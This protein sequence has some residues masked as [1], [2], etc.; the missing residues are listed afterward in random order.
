[1]RIDLAK[2]GLPN[3]RLACYNKR[4]RCL[5]YPGQ[6]TALGK[7]LRE[8]RKVPA[9]PV[10]GWQRSDG[11]HRDYCT[12]GDFMHSKKR[13]YLG[14]CLLLALL[15]AITWPEATR[16][17]SAEPDGEIARF[18]ERRLRDP[19]APP[20][21]PSAGVADAPALD[22]LRLWQITTVDVPPDGCDDVSMALDSSGRP[23]IAYHE[24]IYNDGDLKYAHDD[25]TGWQIQ[26]VDT[27]GNVGGSASLALD[28][29]GRP[30]IAYRDYSH[31]SIKYAYYDG[32]SWHIERAVGGCQAGEVVL[33]LD[34]G[35]QPHISYYTAYP[36]F[37]LRYAHFDGTSWQDELVDTTGYVGGPS[38]AVDAAG[39]PHIFYQ[40]W[41]SSRLRYA[42]FD[43][44]IWQLETLAPGSSRSGT[45]LALDGQ[46]RPHVAYLTSSSAGYGW[47]DGSA[48][49]FEVVPG[50]AGANRPALT[51]DAA[52]RPHISYIDSSYRGV[53]SYRNVEYAWH[54]GSTWSV[55]PVDAATTSSGY[56]YNTTSVAVDAAGMP[57]I[58]YLGVAPAESESIRYAI[59]QTN[60]A[61][62]SRLTFASYRDMN[63]EI[64]AAQ[65][66][67]SNPARLT[68]HGATDS[69]PAY[70]RGCSQ[71]AFDSLRPGNYDLYKMNADGSGITQLT[72]APN[73]DYLA[74]WS[75]DGSKIAYFG[76]PVDAYN[77]EVFVMNADGSGQTRLTWDEAWDGHPTWSPDGS[78]LAFVSG[79]SGAYELWTMN[80]DGSNQQQL[81][82]GLNYPAY[83]DWSPDGSRIVL[84][85]DYNN[86]G[87]LDLAIINADGT[88]LVHPLGASPGNYDRLAPTWSPHGQA[89][90]FARI[91]YIYYQG[92][93]YW[94]DAYIYGLDVS[95][96]SSY[97]L[98]DAGYDWWP[99][100]QPTE[101]VP[102]Q[103]QVGGL[104]Q[105]SAS[106]FLVTWGGWDPGGAGLRSYDVQYREGVD[107]V[108]TDWLL[109]TTQTG[110]TF[111]G[112]DGQTYYFRCRARDYAYNVEP[113]PDG[114]GDA[115][116]T[117]D[118]SP[119]ESTADSP[120]YASTPVFAVTWSGSD[121]NSGI[122][123]YD[124]QYRDG[125]LPWTNWL[126]ATT[127]T[128]AYFAGQINHTYYFQ[129]R[130]RDNVGNLE[131]YPAYYGDTHTHT[132]PYALTGA[133]RGNRA[134]PIALAEV[135]ASPAL[136]TTAF[137]GVDGAFVLYGHATGTYTLS[138]SRDGFGVL[139]GMA[140]V[141]VP[142]ETEPV[143]Y[144]PPGDDRVDDGGFEAGDLLA[145]HPGGE[146]V[147][148]VTNTA[149]TGAYG[150][151]L[152]SMVPPPLVTPT[153]P[154]TAS[155]VLT[156]AGGLVTTSL[157]VLHVPTGA[158]SGTV[159]FTLT[160]V[161]TVTGLPPETQDV[162]PHVAWAAALTDG[163]PLTATLAPL[164]LTVFYSDAA[165][166]AAQVGREET[167][168]LWGYDPVSTTWTPLSGT[169][170]ILRNT[171][172]V[173][174]TAPGLVAL[175]GE[176][177]AGP[178]RGVLVQDVPMTPPLVSGTISL[179]YQVSAD[180]PV[181]DT[182][183]LFLAGPTQ[184]LTYT[185]PLTASGWEHRWWSVP[186]WAGPTLT[187]QLEWLQL[188]RA[189]SVVVVLDEISLGPTAVGG[190]T[191]YLPILAR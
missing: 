131:P 52:G 29:A 125:T 74:T 105:W 138:V 57:H 94:V 9:P 72:A 146:V 63:W 93:W 8:L 46:G 47:Y 69:R 149:H 40:D 102:P 177:F 100:W 27:P 55:I 87:W 45:A 189:P 15:L 3:R 60:V 155:A 150:A 109:D 190:Y 158:V 133:V 54:D 96:G 174:R 184:T 78:K 140:G 145:W 71:I 95:D 41:E 39:H 161:P 117:V 83:P 7:C 35:G 185:L 38:L 113:Y 61:E 66:D 34:S 104:P 92:N 67:G 123:S 169:L 127:D 139:P 135:T 12:K 106:E 81:S 76:Y 170:D 50:T 10:T 148:T 115:W 186:Q 90:A 159:R 110:G 56:N 42:Y 62:W 4:T 168:A 49:H 64:Y 86:D 157:A 132:P 16:G 108:W 36:D 79:R 43:G 20:R 156:A 141:P 180:G 24:T 163:R 98:V 65:G 58:A 48:W 77:A 160:G 33:A 187:V 89:V 118:S 32:L 97:M 23:H 59:Y 142:A 37:D 167:L 13:L 88:G 112:V 91:Q 53:E 152:G 85:D 103:T 116:T 144:L 178:W 162:G 191:I 164:T 122:A 11:D 119:P 176:P 14:T 6:N 171:V 73:N 107:G 101:I 130:A 99:D 114:D 44:T 1:M 173:T 128:A 51:L 136:S 154:F 30:H 165:W 151:R 126:T 120:P 121:A 153:M 84:N 31:N 166:Q 68:I 172:V 111:S 175:L 188:S 124:V 181:S 143:F 5:D 80:A 147:P 25:S 183:Q 70:N 137:S 28:T 134:Q 22:G 82:F 18:R 179:L 2:A 75:P 182:L 129:C 21:F 26:S 19:A 17:Q